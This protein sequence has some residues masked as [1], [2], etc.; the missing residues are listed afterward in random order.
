MNIVLCEC[1]NKKKCDAGNKARNDVVSIL[2]NRGYTHIPLYRSQ[3]NKVKII[4]S[5]LIALCKVCFLCQK[6]DVVFAQ[7]PYYPFEVNK[8]LF[9]VLNKLKTIKRFKTVILIHDISGLRSDK[10][11]NKKIKYVKRELEILDKFDKVICHNQSMHSLFE[12]CDGIGNYCELGPFDYLYKGEKVETHYWD[13]IPEI[14]IAGNLDIQKSKYIYELGCI[15]GAKF[16]LYGANYT[17]ETN[18]NIIYKGKFLP[19]KLVENLSGNFGLVWDGESC[20]A[21]SGAYGQ[22]LK[23]NNPHKFSLYLAAGLPIIIWDNAALAKYVED[24]EIGI[25][26]K[27]LH[28]INEKVK[29]IDLIT[30]S[31]MLNN[32]NKIREKIIM[33]EQLASL[34]I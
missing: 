6:N 26:V 11:K 9:G 4:F 25:C 28:E 3:D 31:K 29:E 22:Y 27:S 10:E 19:D 5:M 30:Y 8:F 2:T 23:Y 21:C 32:V 1:V 14:V 24:N 13:D 34:L 33:G 7:Y 20:D 17:G 12:E 15:Q 16:V 18:Q